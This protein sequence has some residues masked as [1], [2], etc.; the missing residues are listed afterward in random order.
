[1]TATAGF[2]K[3]GVEGVEV[4]LVQPIGGNAQGITVLTK[5]KR[6]GEALEP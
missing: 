5:S 2:V 3:T 1:M 6:C 4:L